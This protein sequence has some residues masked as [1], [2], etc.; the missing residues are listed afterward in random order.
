[1]TPSIQSMN[2]IQ[3][4]YLVLAHEMQSSNETHLSV[5]KHSTTRSKSSRAW[6]S[7]AD[8]MAFLYSCGFDR[9][10]FASAG[11]FSSNPDN[12]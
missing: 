5:T 6:A 11:V 10:A 3:G 12:K 1:M 7:P 8:F 4:I 9:N 2:S